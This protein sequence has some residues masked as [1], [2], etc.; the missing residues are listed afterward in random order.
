MRREAIK[1]IT[2][3]CKVNQAES[4]ALASFA[5]A[6]AGLETRLASKKPGD[7]CVINTCCVTQKAAMQS[8]QAIRK[9]IRR[10]PGATIIATGCYAQ[11]APDAI[12]AIEGVDYIVGQADKHRIFEII[13][14]E[15]ATTDGAPVVVNPSILEKRPFNR[16]PAPAFGGRT[17]PFLKVQDG[18]NAYCTYCI[19]PYSRGRSRSLPPEQ[20]IAELD[21]LIQKGAKEIVLTGIHLGRWG[22]DLPGS[23][24]LYHLIERLLARPGL[25]R[26]RLSSLEPTEITDALLDLIDASPKIC[27]HF[28]IPLQS[29]DAGILKRMNRHCPPEQF[30]E[31][32]GKIRER[33]DD[34]AIGA[35]VMVGFPGETDASFENTRALIDRL[36]LTYLHVFPF[37]P[38]PPAPAA[39]Y[40]DPVPA[41]L[42]RQRAQVLSTLG[43][44]KKEDFF[45]EMKGRIL[46]VIVED[47]IVE[48]KTGDPDLCVKG[49]SSNYIP[50]YIQRCDNIHINQIV[51]CLVTDTDR[52]LSVSGIAQKG[53]HRDIE[54]LDPWDAPGGGCAGGD[55]L[56]HKPVPMQK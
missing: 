52:A 41:G 9:A 44:T 33:F 39:K 51:P 24:G 27:R 38:R 12:Q 6:G 18:C 7:I 53:K 45:K 37:S 47:V 48:K 35:D 34:A 54:S 14:A 16:M 55:A 20:A 3:G 49:L 36:P 2:L 25:K 21:S 10:H 17:R 43:K 15:P 1:F 26:I 4:E 13:G 19:V 5:G 28:H 29:G 56:H 42:I 30:A 23:P 11:M 46:D 32:V 22:A 31:T 8:R 40:P 50:V